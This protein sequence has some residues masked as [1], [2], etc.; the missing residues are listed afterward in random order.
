MRRL[1]SKP[2][3][4]APV[5][6]ACALAVLAGGTYP[7]GVRDAAAVRNA[8]CRPA[9]QPPRETQIARPR[10]LSPVLITEYV[11]APEAWFNGRK[12][13]A[14]GMPGLHRINWLYSARGLAMQGKASEPTVACTTSL[15]PTR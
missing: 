5:V 4:L 14:P 7:A 12:V 9:V 15:A 13:R 1:S 11:P 6:V 8:G 2:R 10:W 3:K